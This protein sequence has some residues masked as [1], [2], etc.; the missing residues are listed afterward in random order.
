MIR[1][2][3]AIIIENNKL[4]VVKSKR[5]DVIISPGGKYEGNESPLE[6]LARELKEEL[7]IKVTSANH[8]KTYQED[9]AFTGEPLS[10]EMYFVN[11]EGTPVP[12]AEIT[13]MHWALPQEI[14]DGTINAASGLKKLVP[15]LKKDG[16]F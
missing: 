5:G 13:N 7:G 3:A 14:I 9:A 6:C 16:Y 2:A 12:S 10:L 11:Y 1:K 8:Y 15:D 4:L